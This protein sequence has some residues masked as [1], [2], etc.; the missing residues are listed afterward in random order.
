MPRDAIYLLRKGDSNNV[1]CAIARGT[2]PR[3]IGTFQRGE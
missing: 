2:T 1:A 3:R